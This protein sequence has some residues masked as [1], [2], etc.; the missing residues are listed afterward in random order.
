MKYKLLML[1]AVLMFSCGISLG[2][3]SVALG[4]YDVTNAR[5]LTPGTDS[6][7]TIDADGKVMPYELRISIENDVILG[8]MS[9]GFQMSSTDGVNWTWNVQPDGLDSLGSK[10]ITVI[11]GSRMYPAGNTGPWDMTGLL[12]Q[13][14]SMDGQLADSMLLGGVALFNGLAV[15]AL[16]QMVAVHFIPGGLTVGQTKTLCFD[17]AFIPPAGNWAFANASGLTF[18]PT[19]APAL[20][21]PVITYSDVAVGGEGKPIPY[22]FSLNQ[23]R[24]NPFNPSTVIDYSV[25]R[26]SQVNISVF[27]ILGQTVKTLVDREADAGQYQAVWDGVDENG[28]QVASGIYFYKMSTA[29]FVETRKMVLMR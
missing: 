27:N 3:N 1:L 29:G 24:P 22:S 9:I 5:M 18:S 7:V 8:G 14:K 17:S 19:I 21:F 2:A 13:E 10:A 26:K 11:S 20:C 25:A 28:N 4:V 16:Q 15:G 12:V 23:N 6:I